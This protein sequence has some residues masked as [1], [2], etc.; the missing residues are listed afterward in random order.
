MNKHFK[1][2]LAGA[3]IVAGLAG[4][5]SCQDLKGELEALSSKVSTLESKVAALETAINAGELVTAV[6]QV[7][8]GVEIVTGKQTYKITNGTNGT[9]G[10][11]GD[12]WT[13]GDDGF[14][15]KNNEK[16][17]WKAVG[18]N[19]TNGTNG[20]YYV[21][22][23]NGFFDKVDANGNRTTTDISYVT[24]AENGVAV[25]WDGR[26]LTLSFKDADGNTVNKVIDALGELKSLVTVPQAYY[27]GAEAV[28]Y[29]HMQYRP[30]TW[31]AAKGKNHLT[32]DVSDE[33]QEI[34]AAAPLYHIY[35]LMKVQYYVN[36]E[37]ADLTGI[38]LS[39]VL[40]KNMD[41][42]QTRADAS[43]NFDIAIDH[44]AEGTRNGRRTLD[45]YYNVV[46]DA[47]IVEAAP[48][49]SKISALALEVK[50]EGNKVTSDYAA[51]Y[52]QNL[53]NIRITDPKAVTAVKFHTATPALRSDYYPGAA[54]VPGTLLNDEHYRRTF[55][56]LDFELAADPDAWIVLNTNPDVVALDP[57]VRKPNYRD[58]TM[59]N[60]H[61]SCDTVVAYNRQAKA[62]GPLDLMTIVAAHNWDAA[63]A[64]CS[65]EE[66]NND[67]LNDL[68]LKWTFEVVRGYQAGAPRTNQENFVYLNSV[69]NYD[70][71]AVDPG[72]PVN[73]LTHAFEVGNDEPSVAAIG[74]HP[75]IRVSLIDPA[76][77]NAIVEAAYIKVLIVDDVVVNADG[78]PC[79]FTPNIGFNCADN[80]VRETTVQW[81]NENIYHVYGDKLTFHA[82]YVFNP[83]NGVAGEVGTV[84]Q[85]EVPNPA[86]GATYTIR[87]TLTPD[88]VWNI[89][90][91]AAAPVTVKRHCMYVWG[92]NTITI[93]LSVVVDPFSDIFNL[94]WN[95][96]A[97]ESDYI[98][99]YWI[100]H[101][102][103]AAM[104]QWDATAY[105]V[106]TP[107]LN[108]V[109]ATKCTFVN[110]INASFV[111]NNG[112]VAGYP[113][114]TLKVVR[115]GVAVRNVEY[116]FHPTKNKVDNH[117]FVN[118]DPT[119]QEEINKVE[120]IYIRVAAADEGANEGLILYAHKGV[121]TAAQA[122]MTPAAANAAIDPNF[123]VPVA[124]IANNPAGPVGQYNTITYQE[125][126]VDGVTPNELA[127]ELLNTDGFYAYIGAT[128]DI[129]NAGAGETTHPATIKFHG[130]DWFKA[131]FLRPVSI[132]TTTPAHFIDAV[133]FGANGSYIR[134]EDIVRPYDWRLPWNGF[135]SHFDPNHANYWQ[136]YGLAPAPY[137]F[138]MHADLAGAT[139]DLG[140]VGSAIPATITLQA[141]DIDNQA[142]YA[143]DAPAGAWA[144]LNPANNEDWYTD[145]A[146]VN[147]TVYSWNKTTGTPLQ[148]VLTAADIAAGK[149][150][151]YGWLT[152]YNNGTALGDPAD[153]S[154][155][156]FNIT[157]PMVVWYKWGKLKTKVTIAVEE[158]I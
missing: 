122:L 36:P 98:A 130:Q 15:Y 16:T 10:T 138:I 49:S 47:A 68:G 99:Q 79:P 149:Q 115:A 1:L 31:V 71:E 73:F 58:N 37:N 121:L 86:T 7:A 75:I 24:V 27:E 131:D 151:N 152:Y 127:F 96:N 30:L 106:A 134:Y 95:N 147:T 140:G 94:D 84:Q 112:T 2:I 78:I 62:E 64:V 133:D 46:G 88:E 104:A 48:A 137:H 97:A 150:S 43:A 25:L 70:V 117:T 29:R 76:H 40:E 116:F 105:N 5:V 39:R 28:I 77:T 107:E 129:C 74:R 124:I 19:G 14:W 82:N 6:R 92:G 148:H 93:E 57:D 156:A 67:D 132:E 12:A 60:I 81:M 136:Y 113:A 108:S 53:D 143:P 20:E 22:N 69:G 89:A 56:G 101:H 119:R 128:G 38:E 32:G 34:A 102:H 50:T 135:D 59:Q 65:L 157:V 91:N 110:D 13:I 123:Y 45:V 66:L 11:S 158:T 114:G 55:Y 155:V 63:G 126:L 18:Q 154:A 109:D 21:P 153:A 72:T 90:H 125:F 145:L 144:G 80:A 23:G 35:P 54:A 103:D 26:K 142:A 61:F 146:G 4:A 141:N 41:Y 9:N 85:I 83:M 42:I 87:W 52:K 17:Q 51:V 118:T 120:H 44:F 8:D 3:A 139:C 111:T 100:G 33:R